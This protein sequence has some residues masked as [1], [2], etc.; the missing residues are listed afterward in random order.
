MTTPFHIR[1]WNKVDTSGGDDACW[2]WTGA[3]DHNGYGQLHVEGRPIVASRVAFYLANGYWPECALHT[4]DVR[5]CVNADHLFD[6]DRNDNMQDKIAKGRQTT[7]RTHPLT[8][9]SDVDVEKIKTCNLS[10]GALATKYK[11]NRST[12]SRIKT[13]KKRNKS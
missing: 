9:L 1:F 5:L 12:I 4:C 6:G 11:V 13:G 7:W 3:P 10:Q 2:F 8:K